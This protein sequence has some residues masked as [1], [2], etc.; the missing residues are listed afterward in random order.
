MKKLFISISILAFLTIKVSGQSYKYL[1]YLDKELKSVEK[2]KAAFIGKGLKDSTFFLVDCF[3]IN[4][5]KLSMSVHF[6]D[7]LLSNFEG[8]YKDYYVSGQIKE[9]GY[10]AN[11]ERQGEWS[12]WDSTGLKTLSILFEKGKQLSLTEFNYYK[13]RLNSK[14]VNDSVGEKNHWF[15]LMRLGMK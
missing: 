3:D 11:G 9:E 13:G 5:G 12:L 1:Y 15:C 6:L 4:T 2:E 10:F 8:L 14:S 7:S